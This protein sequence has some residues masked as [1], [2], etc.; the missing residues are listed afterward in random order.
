MIQDFHTAAHM[1]LSIAAGSMNEYSGEFS[2]YLD[3]VARH[4]KAARDIITKR[5]TEA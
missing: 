2:A 3:Q 1:C 4:M 5:L